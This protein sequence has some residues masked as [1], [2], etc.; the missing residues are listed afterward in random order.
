MKDK[1][2]KL[3]FKNLDALYNTCEGIANQWDKKTIPLNLL[4]ELIDKAKFNSPVPYD[5]TRIEKAITDIEKADHKV[6]DSLYKACKKVAKQ[7]N[8]SEVSLT[9]LKQYIDIVKK[10]FIIGM[11][12]DK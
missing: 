2:Q 9:V 5:N 12:N 8:S 11:E 3:F 10:N 7:M 1:I 6:Y 4:K